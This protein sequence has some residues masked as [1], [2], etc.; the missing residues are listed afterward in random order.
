M[1]TSGH[2]RR[3]QPAIA[4]DAAAVFRPLD[5]IARQRMIPDEALPG[6]TERAAQ[7]VEQVVYDWWEA[8][9]Y[10]K[11]QESRTGETFVISMPPPNVTGALH[12]CHA[13]TAAV[14]A[15]N[16]R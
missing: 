5:R 7:A 1:P 11:P 14:V 13:L 10:F 8:Q 15:L 9:G 3:R 4:A 12:L 2:D 16:S 6:A